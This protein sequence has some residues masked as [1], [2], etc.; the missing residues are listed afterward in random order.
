MNASECDR[1]N[2]EEPVGGERRYG[3]CARHCKEFI[4]EV[5][6]FH[7]NAVMPNGQVRMGT[8]FVK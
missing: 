5:A 8:D 1:I 2:C 3:L 7:A 4:Q 6:D